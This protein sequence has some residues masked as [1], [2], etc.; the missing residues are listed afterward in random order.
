MKDIHHA[1]SGEVVVRRGRS[2]TA[3]GTRGLVNIGL[4]LIV[5]Y[6]LEAKPSI[7]GPTAV[8]VYIYQPIVIPIAEII[9]TSIF[10]FHSDGFSQ[11]Y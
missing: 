2:S 11:T 1:A 10:H 4:P 7:V 3:S 5:D 8:H 6:C 9:I